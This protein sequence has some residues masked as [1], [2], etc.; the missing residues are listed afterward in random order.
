M[1]TTEDLKSIENK[2]ISAETISEQLKCFT[3]GFPYAKLEKAATLNDGIIAVDQEAISLYTKLF[4]T[5]L[6][7]G[8]DIGKFVPA[9]GAAT[10]MFKSLFEYI[11][12]TPEKQE[13]LFQQEPYLTFAKH[14][15]QFAFT[16]DLKE[17]ITGEINFDSLTAEDLNQIIRGVL[18]EDGLNYGALPKGLLKFHQDNKSE[19]TPFEEHLKETAQYATNMQGAGAVHF[20]V[21]P[22]HHDLFKQLLDKTKPQLEEHYTISYDVSF[23]YQK[24]STDT[25]AVNPDN[26]PFRTKNNEL[27]FRPAGHGALIENLNDINKALIFIKN[28]DNVVPEFLQGDTILYKKLLAGLLLEKKETIFSILE[29][30]DNANSNNLDAIIKK[31]IAFLVNELQMPSLILESLTRIEQTALIK[32]KLN[33]PIRVCGMVKNE[34]EPGGGPFWVKQSDGSSS[35]QI[36][37]GAQIDPNDDAQQ[38]ILNESTH[39]N[40]VDLVCYLYDY[41][42]NKFDLKAFIDP[43]TGFISEKT[44]NGLPLKALELPGLWNGAM[45]HWLSFFVEVPVSTF[46]P[47]KTVMDLLRPQHQPE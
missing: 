17:L 9:S 39:F 22:E 7:E 21:S 10:R 16:N 40:P 42:G 28:I 31:G 19:T 24:S 29:G 12:S 37:E 8:L 41:K 38:G 6:K 47:V 15:K 43:T 14:I 2:G 1:L 35:L 30:L 44:Q 5:K 23:S 34:G 11:Q 3:N 45:A 4:N 36:V 13:L 18:L 32:E 20:T 26:T 27:L 33:R 46:N 25:I